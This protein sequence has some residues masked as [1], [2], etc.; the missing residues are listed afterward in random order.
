MGDFVTGLTP[1]WAK[2]LMALLVVLIALD[3][4][5]ELLFRVRERGR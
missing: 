3:L 4:L 2:A 5:K 1:D